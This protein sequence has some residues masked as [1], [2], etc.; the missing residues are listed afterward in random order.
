MSFSFMLAVIDLFIQFS[1]G[2]LSFLYIFVVYLFIYLLI[3]WLMMAIIVIVI[4]M[5][6]A[7]AAVIFY[8]ILLSFWFGAN[9]S[10]PSGKFLFTFY[11]LWYYFCLDIEG[12][13]SKNWSWFGSLTSDIDGSFYLI[14]VQCHCHCYCGCNLQTSDS[15]LSSSHSSTNCH[16]HRIINAMN[17]L[18]NLLVNI[19]DLTH[20]CLHT[21]QDNAFN[22]LLLLWKIIEYF[23]YCLHYY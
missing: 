5:V 1:K 7:V 12:N 14:C 10:P 21:Y 20:I 11:L 2:Y 13:R 6:V 23:H 9:S 8:S 15:T 17:S 16:H 4:V 19:I 22:P 3:D 18:I